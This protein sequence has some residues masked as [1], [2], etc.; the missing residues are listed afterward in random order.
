MSVRNH[1]VNGLDSNVEARLYEASKLAKIL[2]SDRSPILLTGDINS[3]TQGLV[4][5]NIARDQLHDAFQEAGN[6][7]GY[8]YGQYI[9][10]HY[11]G[12]LHL[13]GL[14]QPYIRIDHILTTPEWVVTNCWTGSQTISDHVPVYADMI[15]KAK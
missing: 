8:S 3:P 1:D 2:E 4:F 14:G 11:L 7:Y 9:V 13:P 12:K 15:L 10:N 6:G 5:K